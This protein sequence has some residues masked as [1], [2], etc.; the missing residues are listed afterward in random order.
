MMRAYH[1]IRDDESLSYDHEIRDEQGLSY[2]IRDDESL[3]YD[4]EIR[5]EKGLS[6]DKG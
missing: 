6:Y 1:M 2:M 4:H 3:S 5:D